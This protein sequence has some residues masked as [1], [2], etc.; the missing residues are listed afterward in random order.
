LLW[1]LRDDSL[2]RGLFLD[3]LAVSVAV[4]SRLL[5]VAV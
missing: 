4:T 2:V 5:L 1:Q 3:N